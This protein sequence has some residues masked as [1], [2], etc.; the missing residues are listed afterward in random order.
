MGDNCGNG[1]AVMVVPTGSNGNCSV[2]DGGT[3]KGH[4]VLVIIK[5]KIMMVVVMVMTIIV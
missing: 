3:D 4:M 2:D 1:S 5:L